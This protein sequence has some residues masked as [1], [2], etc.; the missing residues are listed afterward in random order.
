MVLPSSTSVPL[1]SRSQSLILTWLC[2]VARWCSVGQGA[3]NTDSVYLFP[4]TMACQGQ[5]L[6]FAASGDNSNVGNSENMLIRCNWSLK[7]L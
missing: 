5:I 3:E 4:D 2:S 6:S 7:A 1:C